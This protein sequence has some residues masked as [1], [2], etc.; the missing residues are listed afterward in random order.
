MSS[1]SNT[2][3]G[4]D[5]TESSNMDNKE[6]S[7]RIPLLSKSGPKEKVVAPV[8]T[9]SHSSVSTSS[10]QH[11][12]TACSCENE[13]NAVICIVCSNVL[14]PQLMRNH[15]RCESKTCR[16]GLYINAGDYGLCQVCGAPKP[17]AI[18]LE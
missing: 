13:A 7:T 15:W 9:E 10:K 3:Q 18:L 6:S 1:K 12:C 11:I 8:G 5:D 14:K 4:P 17:K 16:G 2:G